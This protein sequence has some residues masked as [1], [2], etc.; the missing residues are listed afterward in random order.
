MGVTP[1]FRKKTTLRACKILYSFPVNP[2][3]KGNFKIHARLG[4]YKKRNRVI[5]KEKD[6]SLFLQ[7]IHFFLATDNRTLC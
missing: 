7:G 6:R 3:T 2:V 5:K 4:M 1:A